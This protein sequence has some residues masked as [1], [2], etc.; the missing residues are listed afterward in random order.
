MT[1]RSVTAIDEVIVDEEMA[2]SVAVAV[3]VQPL[4][5]SDVQ[6][7]AAVAALIHNPHRLLGASAGVGDSE[8]AAAGGLTPRAHGAAEGGPAIFTAPGE[9]LVGVP[10][11]AK[12]T[13]GH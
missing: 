11:G 3:G 6:V 4:E 2:L 5:H 13:N 10:G 7:Q 12:G 8:A 9:R 1:V